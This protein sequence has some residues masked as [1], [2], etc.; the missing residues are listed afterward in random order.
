ME[1]I[2]LRAQPGRHVRGKMERVKAAHPDKD[3][4]LMRQPGAEMVFSLPMMSRQGVV[5]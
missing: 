4:K 2:S 5:R 1:I 3:I